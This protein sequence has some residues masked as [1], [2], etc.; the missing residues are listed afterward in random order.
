MVS[1]I[2]D[3]EGTKRMRKL[4]L[5]RRKRFYSSRVWDWKEVN[6]KLVVVGAKLPGIMRL[7]TE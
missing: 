1:E 3:D 6:K 2:R 4:A 5:H 7:R